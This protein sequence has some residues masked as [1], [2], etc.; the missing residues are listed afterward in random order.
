M[1]IPYPTDN[2]VLQE[3]IQLKAHTLN[4]M[5]FYK[6]KEAKTYG[7]TLN[8]PTLSLQGSQKEERER[9]RT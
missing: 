5:V 1:N 3:H 8:S 9:E 4:W 2:N 7:T 6:G